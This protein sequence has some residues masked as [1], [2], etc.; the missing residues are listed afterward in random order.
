M[1]L[2]LELNVVRNILYHNHTVNLGPNPIGQLIES[3]QQGLGR[4]RLTG[5]GET[6]T[7]P[8]SS[9]LFRNLVYSSITSTVWCSDPLRGMNGGWK[10]V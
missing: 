3:S 10:L 1:L 4:D 8:L 9:G 6:V 7:N 5:H 2:V